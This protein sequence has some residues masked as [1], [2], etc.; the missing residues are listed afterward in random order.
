MTTYDAR[1]SQLVAGRVPLLP[2][3][4]IT[5]IFSD[6]SPLDALKRSDQKGAEVRHALRIASKD[7]S[8]ALDPW[9]RGEPLRSRKA[10]LRALA[11]VDRMA[12]R[13]TPFGLFAGIGMVETGE[14]GTLSV[15]E[16]ARRTC[17]RIDMG[18]ISDM[19]AALET[20]PERGKISYLSNAAAIARGERLYVTNL[21]LTSV[22]NDGAE[23]TT[24]QI[25]VR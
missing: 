13:C 6:P 9:L 12:S 20:G 10:P 21:A 4:A 17:T 7:L 11:Y 3:S 14:A 25:P 1:R 16:G 2:I 15:D 5:E 8:D 24:A 23:A 18:L 22:V 19:A